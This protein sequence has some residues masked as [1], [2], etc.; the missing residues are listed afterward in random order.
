[1]KDYKFI[2]SGGNTVVVC[3]D[4]VLLPPQLRDRTL[5]KVHW[6]KVEVAGVA[7]EGVQRMN[8]GAIVTFGVLGLGAKSRTATVSIHHKDGSVRRYVK[9]NAPATEVAEAFHV[10]GYP[11]NV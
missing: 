4:E 2:A 9:V 5:R 8:V 3:D 6:P 1:M 10:R 11:V 7:V